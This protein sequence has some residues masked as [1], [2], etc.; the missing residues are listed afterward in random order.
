MKRLGDVWVEA[1][2]PSA[3][4]VSPLPEDQKVWPPGR[5]AAEPSIGEHG[6]GADREEPKP[7][8]SS[9]NGCCRPEVPA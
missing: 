2:I 6:Q 1:V 5:T 9:A 4:T 3:T 7:I 8:C